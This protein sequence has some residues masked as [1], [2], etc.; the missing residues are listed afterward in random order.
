MT[1]KRTGVGPAGRHPLSVEHGL[2]GT[3]G[4]AGAQHTRVLFIGGVIPRGPYPTPVDL[5]AYGTPDHA[6]NVYQWNMIK[7]IERKF[8]GIARIISTPF[9]SVAER[10]SPEVLVPGFPWSHVHSARDLSLGF[11][12]V[13]GLRNVTRELAL[14]GQLKK[15]FGRETS[16]R[17]ELLVFVYSMHG[18]FL[19]QL[20][21][22][23]RRRPDAVICLVVP[24]LP[25][26][27]RD[28]ANASRLRRVLKW[29]DIRRNR[30]CLKH[31]DKYVLISSHQ[32]DALGI[33]EE[34][35]VVVE[36]MTDHEQGDEELDPSTSVARGDMF[37]I[38]YTGG[39][40]RRYGIVDLVDSLRYIQSGPVRLVLCGEGDAVGYID[41][42][43]RKE[44]RISYFGQVS[45]EESL[46]WQRSADLLV[47]PRPGAADFTRYSF[48]SKTLEYLSAGKPVLT[49][50][51]DGTP[52]EYDA[53]LLYIP[54]PGP[55]G[56][57]QAIEGV[58]AMSE[59][60]RRRI[61]QR[62]KEFVET[63]KSVD[64]QMGRVLAFIGAGK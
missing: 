46:R 1:T 13:F 37:T 21:L 45:R 33:I 9:L 27:M 59:D 61:G 11:L 38:V 56:I 12:N 2:I 35:F 19:Q 30:N 40:D 55:E 53:H 43:A 7:G 54:A 15:F 18:P 39:I 10:L 64:R 20:P 28:Y 58:M 34:Q 49:F 32:A 5:T 8:G 48:P 57:A 51:N 62:A 63:E 17:D 42:A 6:S 47:N 14:R 23:K 3:A 16:D 50:H 22:I 52:P 44:P 25:E 36:G 60:E 24:D 31:V 29:I 41:S 26:H 4:T